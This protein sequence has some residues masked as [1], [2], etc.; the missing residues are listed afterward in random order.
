MPPSPSSPE[1]TSR[2][3]RSK[4][5]WAALLATLVCPWLLTAPTDSARAQQ[6]APV[7][8]CDRL[9]QPPRGEMG[10]VP[11]YADG[12]PYKRLDKGRAAA[13]CAEAMAQWP[14]EARFPAYA[15][16]AASGPEYLR[17]VRLAAS[18][19][20]PLGQ[21]WMA[22][23]YF[24]GSSAVPRDDK[25]ALGLFRLAAE[26]GLALAQDRMAS[27]YQQGILGLPRDEEEAVT[28]DPPRCRRGL[29]GGPVQ[30]G[31]ILPPR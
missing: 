20:H 5:A 23:E 2:S 8:D 12:V 19:G 28:V 18:K 27:I 30:D 22:R 15:I 29:C 1:A 24:S 13:A 21:Y 17:L 4:P 11:A 6:P 14:E 31:R 9:A 16:Y 25:Q 10:S 26:A 3:V 7:H